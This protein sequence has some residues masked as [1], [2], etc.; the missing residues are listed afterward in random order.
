MKKIFVIAF[1]KFLSISPLYANN[2][3]YRVD[4]RP[5]EEVFLNDSQG[6][7]ARGR[8]YNLSMH[9][10]GATASINGSGS[11]GL[12]SATDDMT[13]ANN[14]A[15]RLLDWNL[16]AL[17]SGLRDVYIYQ[18][19]QT[20][21]FYSVQRSLLP[22]D[23]NMGSSIRQGEWIIENRIPQ[24]LIR[25]AWHLYDHGSA[26]AARDISRANY[27]P[28]S[29]YNGGTNDGTN[30]EPYNGGHN[31]IY[32]R[33]PLAVSLSPLVLLPL[34]A[35]LWCRDTSTQYL[36]SNSCSAEKEKYFNTRTLINKA[37]Y[38]GRFLMY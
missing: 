26:G 30:M 27:L 32:Q 18:I 1:M 35:T 31:P 12:I 17:G 21:D 7:S 4:T 20:R 22:D 9:V 10:S 19:A 11:T 37:L 6:F 16:P 38:P 34:S 29:R 23:P 14:Y 25:G 2:F 24:N 8:D 36:R 28:N 3:L 5:P 33:D 13:W 15:R